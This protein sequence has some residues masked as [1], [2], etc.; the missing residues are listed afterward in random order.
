MD[1]WY[2]RPLEHRAPQGGLTGVN[3]RFYRGGE[4]LPFYIPR[5]VMPQIDEQFY[6]EFQTFALK[7]GVPLLRLRMEPRKLRAHQRIDAIKSSLMSE[8]V[9]AKPIY[10]SL[11]FY[12]LD[13]N[14]RWLAHI[15]EGSIIECIQIALPF[16]QAVDLMFQFPR[17]YALQV[18]EET[19]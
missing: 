13:G 9:R 16:A 4:I 5:P 8:E 11:D 1:N 17:T 7:R 15:N 14:H 18:H 3:G 10:I 19:N 6:P 12:V 2:Q